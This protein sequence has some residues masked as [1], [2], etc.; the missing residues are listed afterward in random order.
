MSDERSGR[1]YLRLV[2]LGA[3]V[4]VPAA[5]VAALFLAAVHGL[6]DWLWG[7]PHWYLVLGL[8]VVGAGVVLAARTML[9]GDGGHEPLEGIGGKPTPMTHAPGVALAAIGTLAFGGVLGPEGPLIA[10]G[11]VV[12]LTVTGALSIRPPFAPEPAR[13]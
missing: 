5:L 2:V 12:G 7:D 4:G 6:E 13:P 11:S 1:A 8:P 9:P 3:L 10:L